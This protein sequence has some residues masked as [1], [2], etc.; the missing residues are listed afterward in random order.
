MHTHNA[1]KLIIG[2]LLILVLF[3]NPVQA[4]ATSPPAGIKICGYITYC[5]EIGIW[6][7]NPTVSDYGG[8]QIWF[9]DTFKFNS[10]PTEFFYSPFPNITVLG[11]HT[12]STR[13]FD[14]YGNVNLTW[15]NLTVNMAACPSCS[16]GWFCAENEYCYNPN[17]TPTPTPTVTVSVTPTSWINQTYNATTD[18]CTIRADMGETWVRWDANCNTTVEVLYYIDGVKLENTTPYE[19]LDPNRLILSD[20]KPG[21][22]HN[23]KIYYLGNIVAE[24]TIKT[25]PSWLMILFFIVL[26]LVLSITGLLFIATPS[27]RILLGALALAIALWMFTVVTGWMLMLPLL[28]AI[29]AIIGI[30]LALR[31]QIESSWG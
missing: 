18:I 10:S 15:V 12:F 26:S 1:G 31:D 25:L 30:I 2:I 7:I 20:L 16:E 24:S 27:Y 19:K 8:A 21:E 6:W 11:D 22:T 29:L 5:N 17:G 28:P 13:T 3:G 9:D 23:L 14:T 4:N